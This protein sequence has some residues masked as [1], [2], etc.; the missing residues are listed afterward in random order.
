MIK[1]GAVTHVEEVPM[2]H[3]SLLQDVDFFLK[4]INA[5]EAEYTILET[6]FYR[7]LILEAANGRQSR[8][9]ADSAKEILQELFDHHPGTVD[10]YLKIIH[11]RQEELKK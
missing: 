10:A 4:R 6:D 9:A 8:G 3:G 2:E 5:E 7:E 11:R 1:L